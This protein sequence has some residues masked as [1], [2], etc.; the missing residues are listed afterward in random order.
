MNELFGIPTGALAMALGIALAGGLGALGLLAA[1][2]RIFLKLAL[3]NVPRRRGRSALII[4]GLMLGTAIIAAALSTGDTMSHTIR[5]S[6]VTS[7][8][9]TDELVSVK[10]TDMES[11]AIGY[12]TRFAYFNEE[13]ASSVGDVAAQ[14][15]LVRAGPGGSILS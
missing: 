7:L 6:V 14:S 15:T 1:R 9:H 5:S 2:N 8:G 12:S 11:T 10:G 13:T 3:R 4:A